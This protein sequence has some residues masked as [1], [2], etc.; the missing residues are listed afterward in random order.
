[1]PEGGP[2]IDDVFLRATSGQKQARQG[3]GPVEVRIRGTGLAEAEVSLAGQSLTVMSRADGELV[4][5]WDVPHGAN[6]GPRDLVVTTPGGLATRPAELVVTPITVVAGAVPGLGTT[7]SPFADLAQGLAVAGDGDEVRATG[8]FVSQTVLAIGPG[9]VLRGNGASVTGAETEVGLE[10]EDRAQLIGL[11]VKRHG[12]VCVS[13]IGV[14]TVVADLT[15]SECTVGI[16]IAPMATLE[17]RD[18][19]LRRHSSEAIRHDGALLTASHLDLE[20]EA[21][22]GVRVL[23]GTTLISSSTLTAVPPGPKLPAPLL[24]YVLSDEREVLLLAKSE[25]TLEDVMVHGNEL[26][27][28]TLKGPY[29]KD[30]IRILNATTITVL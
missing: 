22:V 9:V 3:E 14:D 2:T 16:S 24:S 25:I 28:A 18:A 8:D 20:V 1:M 29:D 13:I 12:K 17:L 11:E 21:G 5:L 7:D 10:L 27:P 26:P 30:S 23:R 15:I 19:V 4:A 6:L